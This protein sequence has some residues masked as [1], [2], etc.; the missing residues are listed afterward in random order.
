MLFR[1]TYWKHPEKNSKMLKI[2]I[3]SADYN[4]QKRRLPIE[5]LGIQIETVNQK[6]EGMEE[7]CLGFYSVVSLPKV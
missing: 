4:L 5:M 3:L 7:D 2:S 1:K 6:L